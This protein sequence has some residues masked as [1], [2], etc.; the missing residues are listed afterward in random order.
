MRFL[1][2]AGGDISLVAG[3]ACNQPSVWTHAIRIR[4][5]AA[6]RHHHLFERPVDVDEGVECIAALNRCR[7]NQVGIADPAEGRLQSAVGIIQSCPFAIVVNEAVPPEVWRR[8]FAVEPDDGATVV[9]GIGHGLSGPG[10]VQF[11]RAAIAESLK[12]MNLAGRIGEC[13]YDRPPAVRSPNGEPA[14]GFASDGYGQRSDGGPLHGEWRATRT[15]KSS[16]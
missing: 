3:K 8:C 5:D 7:S 6:I 2:L 9:D 16:R 12:S 13:S 4:W 10:V 11:D 1:S 14:V 15:G